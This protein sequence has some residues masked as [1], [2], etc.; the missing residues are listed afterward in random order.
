[1][2][3]QLCWVNTYSGD[4]DGAAKAETMLIDLIKS[5]TCTGPAAPAR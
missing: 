2:L 3:M 5:R 4:P 1:M